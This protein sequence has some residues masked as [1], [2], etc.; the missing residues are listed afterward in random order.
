MDTTSIFHSNQKNGSV[1]YYTFG[2]HVHLGFQ[3]FSD[4]VP[5]VCRGGYL[6]PSKCQKIMFI[7]ALSHSWIISS[8]VTMKLSAT[9]SALVALVPLVATQQT[10]SY[11]VPQSFYV[12]LKSAH[13]FQIYGQC[14]LH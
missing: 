12:S 7:R 3:F 8:V 5:D 4:D 2:S 9:F 11:K 13:F 10:V 1:V 6:T 14:A